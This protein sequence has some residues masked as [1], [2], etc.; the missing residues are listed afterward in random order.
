ME[1]E[2]FA[3]LTVR[4]SW[5]EKV[6]SSSAGWLAGGRRWAVD[7]RVVVAGEQP[8]AGRD[9]TR[10]GLEGD[11]IET[12]HWIGRSPVFGRDEPVGEVVLSH[13]DQW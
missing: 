9:V 6:R 8:G 5:K 3:A 12:G 1:G 11:W 10:N 7:V 13:A 2:S 4:V